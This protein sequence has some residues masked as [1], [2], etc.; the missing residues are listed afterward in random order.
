M[1]RLFP[2]TR[3]RVKP[4]DGRAPVNGDLRPIKSVRGGV[5]SHPS[6]MER[7]TKPTV[8]G[9]GN[10]RLD[11]VLE[12]VAFSAKPMPLVTLL[13]EAPKRVA[14]IFVQAREPGNRAGHRV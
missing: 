13:D 4:G 2:R 14:A 9:Q 3:P 10:R 7:A 12:L 8:H 1:T 5:D 11:G 6:D